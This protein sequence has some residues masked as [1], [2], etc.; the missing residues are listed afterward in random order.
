[1]LNELPYYPG[2]EWRVVGQDLVLIALSTAIVT[3]IINGVFD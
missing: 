2:Y 3:S 1:M